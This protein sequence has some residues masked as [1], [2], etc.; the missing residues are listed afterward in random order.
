MLQDTRIPWLSNL[1]N[2]LIHDLIKNYSYLTLKLQGKTETL[3]GKALCGI[4]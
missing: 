3:K 4:L 2:D 1:I